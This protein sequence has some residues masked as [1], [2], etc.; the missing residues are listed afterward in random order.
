MGGGGG[1]SRFSGDFF[2]LAGP[3]NFVAVTLAF[4]K[5]SGIEKRLENRGI[6]TLSKFFFVSLWRKSSWG[7]PSVFQKTSGMGKNY[8]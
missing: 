2:C 3:K 8:G 6:T 4:Q 5:C 1:V 7:N